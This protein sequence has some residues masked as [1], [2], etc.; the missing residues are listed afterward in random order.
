MKYK[1][2]NLNKFNLHII[3][4]EKFKTITLKIVFK[5]EVKKE[6]LTI[7]PIPEE[8]ELGTI[9]NPEIFKGINNIVVETN[10]GNMQIEDKISEHRPNRRIG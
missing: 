5:R 9:S 2:Y 4:T 8:I 7:L 3:K 10:V 6:D 1:K